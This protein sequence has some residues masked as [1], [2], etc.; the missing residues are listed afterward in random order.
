MK[1]V[2]PIFRILLLTLLMCLAILLALSSLPRV[3]DVPPGQGSP[4]AP[5]Y[6]WNPDTLSYLLDR[7]IRDAPAFDALVVLHQGQT[8][9]SFGKPQQLINCHGVQNSIMNLLIGIALEKGYLRL[10]QSVDQP[11]D[12]GERLPTSPEKVMTI[13]DLLLTSPPTDPSEPDRRTPNE[14]INV[15]RTL[16]EQTTGTPLGQC[17]YNWLAVPLQMQDF[18]PGNVVNPHPFCQDPSDF[19]VYMSARDLA[20]I[21]AVLIQQGYWAGQQVLAADWIQACTQA[22]SP[23]RTKMAPFDAYGYGWW[24]DQA[25]GTYWATGYEGQFLLVDPVAELVIVARNFTGN[26]WLTQGWYQLHPKPGSRQDVLD[27]HDILRRNLP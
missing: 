11:I 22:W 13:R 5:A 20:R 21:G 1:R 19:G 14:G 16:L 9:L 3:P 27:I 12:P 7:L 15:L 26:S 2:W 17:F 24:L 10:D 25:Q 18:R 23:V 6:G 4:L 8:V